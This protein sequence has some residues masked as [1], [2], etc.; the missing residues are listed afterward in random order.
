MSCSLLHIQDHRGRFLSL[1]ESGKLIFSAEGD[2]F[3]LA[4]LGRSSFCLSHGRSGQW[5]GV[6]EGEIGLSR[7]PA[8][9]EFFTDLEKCE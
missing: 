4:V 2:S 6:K 5:I 3:G 9:L 8:V 7:T 1:Q